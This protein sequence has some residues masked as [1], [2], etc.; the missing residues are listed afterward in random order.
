MGRESTLALTRQAVQAEICKRS[1]YHFLKR[2]WSLAVSAEPIWNW[3]I[4][5]ICDEAQIACERVFAG[6]PVE[7]DLLINVPPGSTKSTIISIMLPAW[8]WTRMERMRIIGTSHNKDLALDLARKSRG[9]VKSEQYI[10][11]FDIALKHDQDTKTYFENEAG[12]DRHAVGTD[13]SIIGF[14]GDLILVDDPVNPKGARSELEIKGVNI[15]LNEGIFTRKTDKRTALIIMVMQRLAETDPSAEM[16]RRSLEGTE[17]AAPVKHI[18]LPADLRTG[19]TFVKPQRLVHKYVDDLLDPIRMPR[20]VLKKE[21]LR[22]GEYGYA[23]QYDQNPVPA[24]GGMFKTDRIRCDRPTP[25]RSAFKRVARYWDKAGTEGDGAYTAGVL[26]ALHDIKDAQGKVVETNIWILDVIRF[27]EESA[28]RER[29]IRQT[30]EMDG[31]NVFIGVEQEPGS[32]GKDSVNATIRSTLFG[33]SVV[34]DKVT[35]DKAVRADP[36]SVQ[37]NNG[38]CYVKPGAEWWPAF[39]DEMKLF[40]VGRYRDQTDAASGCF[41]LLTNRLTVG[42]LGGGPGSRGR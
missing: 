9:V 33:F 41:S 26:M 11:L 29:I 36:F 27:Q 7:Y 15:A 21:K 31:K 10:D 13:G 6:L 23:G 40:P 37:V 25:P 16:L 38:N 4:K 1:F 30:A 35:G 34:G 8:C 42:A 20:D 24:E 12:G 5:Y 14:H 17:G 32:G 2:H 22:L 19:R 39:R 3:H 18:C 28:T